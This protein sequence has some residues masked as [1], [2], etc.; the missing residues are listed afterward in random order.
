MSTDSIS[1]EEAQRLQEKFEAFTTAITSEPQA[2]LRDFAAFVEDLIGE[3]EST[4]VGVGV[5]ARVLH[6]P[7]TAAR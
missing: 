1:P 5:A 6:N 3:V 7:I 2:T 4:G